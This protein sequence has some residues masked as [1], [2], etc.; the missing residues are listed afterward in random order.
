MSDL[1]K[2]KKLIQANK[3]NEAIEIL[4]NI[5]NKNSDNPETLYLLSVLYYSEK[6]YNESVILAKKLIQ[7]KNDNLSQKII[8]KSYTKMGKF[9]LAKKALMSSVSFNKN[10]AEV[11]NL[12]G[13]VNSKLQKENEA[14]L[15]F[16]ESIKLN[17]KLQPPYFN[18]ME[19]YEKTN[20]Y[21]NL[22]DIIS[23]FLLKFS[24]NE[25]LLFYSS[26]ILENQNKINEAI[27]ILNNL[28]FN[29]N[30]EWEVKKNYRLGNLN[31]KNKNFDRAFSLYIKA[32]KMRLENID[33]NLF[34]N[35]KFL[36]EIKN[37]NKISLEHNLDKNIEKNKLDLTFIV[38]FPRSG[39]TLLDT[40]LRSNS[41]TF[42]L[43]EKPLVFQTIRIL[44]ENN[45]N[46][47]SSKINK[48]AEEIYLELLKR[49]I[50][51]SEVYKKILI[52]R[53]PLNIARIPLIKKIFPKSKIIVC[54][55]HPLDCVFSSFAQDFAI[56]NAMINFLDLERS[57][58]IYNIVMTIYKN[59]KLNFSK[60]RIYEIKYEELVSN[61]KNQILGLL[62]FLNLKWENNMN[63]Y[64]KVAN[65]RQ[66]IRT[67]SYNQVNK[68]LYNSSIYK[69][70][71][72]EKKL[73][74]PRDTLSKWEIYF[75]YS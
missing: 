38:G 9:N 45:L 18:L 37:Y 63:D 12:L 68:E 58:E 19:M 52:D 60:N 67:A 21:K 36:E 44:K 30:S 26:I 6:H 62:K 35:N 15:N 29:K 61:Y 22:A 2:I 65:D 10:D 23:N 74:K 47:N 3:N 17:P 41:K 40:I 75:N 53:N 25:Y 55:R 20:Q 66:R 43:E 4:K 31:H 57:A 59:S 71:N 5:V 32:N 69:W 72:Y 50:N 7:I 28:S 8:A 54:V 13:I 56:N 48:Y 46:I 49:H 34:K 73:K 33:N 24:S 70:K 51:V 39:T 42:L 16:E 11:Y 1:D 64:V 27:K 14:V